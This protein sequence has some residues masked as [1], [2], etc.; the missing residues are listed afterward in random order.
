M[1]K[2]YIVNTV[3][4]VVIYL[5]FLI[6]IFVF[7]DST[8]G[9]LSS[10]FL[11][12]HT[13]LIDYMRLNFWES[14]DFFPQWLMNYGLG[15]SF[16]VL[17]YHGL[18][19]PFL[20]IMYVLPPVNPIFILE[21]VY[22][23]L[24]T[25][26]TLA[27][28]KLL[29]LNKIHGNLNTF[30]AVLSSFSGYFIFHMTTH[31]MFIYY[32]PIMVCS[33]IA[34]HLLA[35]S[36]I[37]SLYTIC[38]G[39][40]FFTNFTF[41]PIISVL[42]FLYYIGLLVE[43]KS[44]NIKYLLRF[45]ASYGL[46]VG[47]GMMMLIPQGLQVVSAS[48]RGLSLDTNYN[49]LLPYERIIEA[50]SINSYISG[51]FVFAVAAL[52][53]AAFI[54]RTKRFYIMLIP[55][56]LILF[57]EPINVAFNLFEYVHLKIYIWY[58]PILW[59]MFGLVVK[60]A[61]NKQLLAILG[62][63]LVLIILGYQP[64]Q[65]PVLIVLLLAALF[66]NY[67]AL[68]TTNKFIS[69]LLVV[70]FCFTSLAYNGRY[71][72]RQDLAN[73]TI[74]ATVEEEPTY[75]N[76]RSLNTSKNNLDSISSFTP[77]IYTSLENG[78]YIEAVR[79]EYESAKSSYTRDTKYYTFDNPYY[80][81]LFSLPNSNFSS[82]PIVYGVE[83]SDTVNISAYE[84]LNSSQTMTAVN[85]KLFTTDSSNQL[86]QDQFATETL[87]SDARPFTLAD[88][89]NLDVT[90]PSQYQN[91]ILT[92][93][94]YADIPL[95]DSVDQRIYVNDQVNYT[96][97]A[98]RYGINDNRTVTFIFD[99]TQNPD[100]RI[101]VSNKKGGDVTYTNLK[102]TYQSFD[103]FNQNKLNPI[104]PTNFAVDLNDS[105]SFEIDME[106]DGY[107]AT[108]IPYDNGFTFTIDDEEVES[109]I[110][111]NLYVGSKISKGTHK[112]ILSYQIPGFKIGLYLT[113]ISLVITIVLV[114]HDLL[115]LKKNKWYIQ[116]I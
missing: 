55:M 74:N 88:G 100:L 102:V 59:L 53:G 45:I 50:M 92:I 68:V 84:Q 103:D 33:L 46:G 35:S 94:M 12:Q 14:K 85:Q 114:T 87:I 67:F 47:I 6:A 101:D 34:L 71:V 89:Y 99:T 112:V 52:L 16:S 61:N 113:T 116:L 8:L 48:S 115:T 38:V 83:S 31:P 22:L 3:T 72:N 104:I 37:K 93:T 20:L 9:K 54:I 40:I 105:Y 106:E 15:Q 75:T 30:I 51:M 44:L 96:M 110:V 18:Y 29:D 70:C 39:L 10:D 23:M 56:L 32:L 42:Q 4:T 17:Y 80:Q 66:V 28:T 19:N 25:I 41:A 49:L 77:N 62:S 90:V 65:N 24:I 1:N 2:R 98:D 64:Y 91:G 57:I 5:L 36:K 26:N 97:Y 69:Y 27:M 76:S 63:S 58:M 79:D 109:E 60:K 95:D 107:I 78:Y 108:T 73:F 21:L 11:S 82:N 86:Y 81:N 43:A 7:F 111:N 13:K